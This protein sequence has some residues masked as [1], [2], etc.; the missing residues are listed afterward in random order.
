MLAVIVASL[1]VGCQPPT[2][3]PVAA[4]PTGTIRPE[5][6]GEW[7]LT[8]GGKSTITLDKDGGTHIVAEAKFQ[9]K[10]MITDVRGTWLADDE[11][12]S[13]RRKGP[14]GEEF[15]VDYIYKL[16]GD[17][18]SISR[19]ETKLVQEYKRKPIK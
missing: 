15:T 3:E 2:T 1:L 14:T 18:L 13:M 17:T 10:P 9:G 12:L 16:E 4:K 19:Q 8:E 5:L 11:H 7:S 6:I